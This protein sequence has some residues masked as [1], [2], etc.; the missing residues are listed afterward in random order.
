MCLQIIP[1]SK[2]IKTFSGMVKIAC[3]CG[4]NLQSPDIPCENNFAERNLRPVVIARN[5]SFGCQSDQGMRTR[6]FLMSVIQTIKCQGLDPE[7]FIQSVLNSKCCNPT[8]DPVAIFTNFFLIRS[9]H[10]HNCIK[11][12]LTD[13]EFLRIFKMISGN[14]LEKLLK[15]AIVKHCPGSCGQIKDFRH[16]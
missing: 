11:K 8:T 16:F 3:S 4:P 14:E 9:N 7:L 6:E 5:M 13:Y 10:L 2:L 12:S 1:L 15:D